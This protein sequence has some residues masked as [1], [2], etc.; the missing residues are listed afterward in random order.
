MTTE[1][2][3]SFCPV[4]R[5]IGI[6]QEKWVLH[7]IRSLLA[8]DKGF[9][10]LSRSVGGCNPATLAQRLDHLERLGLISKTVT[11]V[12]PPRSHYA[13]TASGRELQGV[14]DEIDR[15]SRLHLPQ[16][17]RRAEDTSCA[18]SPVTQAH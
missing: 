11:S 6:L 1:V 3:G 10:E 7:I 14:I 13:L 2:H 18:A 9:N 8:A 15:W 12:M 5:A 17:D 4:H 16:E